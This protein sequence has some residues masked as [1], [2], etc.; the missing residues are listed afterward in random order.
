[1]NYYDIWVDLAP[2]ANDLE[3]VRSVQAYLQHFQMQGK[4]DSYTIKRRKFG[5]SPPELGEFHIS[6]AFTSLAQLDAAFMVAAT[7][8]ESIEHLHRAV[9]SRVINFKSALYRSFP[10]EVRVS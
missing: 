10:D 7:R 9:Y 8:D 5:F 3:F 2:G 6:I 4:L 1:V